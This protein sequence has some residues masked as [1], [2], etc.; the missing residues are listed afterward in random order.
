MFLSLLEITLKNTYLDPSSA[1]NFFFMS[2][3]FEQRWVVLM[4]IRHM[5][6]E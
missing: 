2:T 6:H 4:L 1:F 3:L 5:P